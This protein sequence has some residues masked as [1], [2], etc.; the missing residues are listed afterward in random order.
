[1]KHLRAFYAGFRQAF[2]DAR[3]FLR[4]FEFAGSPVDPANPLNGYDDEFDGLR[5]VENAQ[6]QWVSN[7]L[8]VVCIVL[9]VGVLAAVRG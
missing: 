3:Q 9:V 5:P 4:I 6:N 8:V 7:A 1:M 2:V